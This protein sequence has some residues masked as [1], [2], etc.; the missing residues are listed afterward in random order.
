[1]NKKIYSVV[2]VTILLGLVLTAC[3]RPA[4]QAPAVTPTSG[5]AEIPF[6]IP[7]NPTVSKDMITK[8]TQTAL[9]PVA[10]AATPTAIVVVNTPAATQPPA[11]TTAPTKAPVVVPTATPGLPA[12]Y[13][14]QKGEFPYCIARRFNLDLAGFL[15]TNGLTINSR[16]AEGTDLKIPTGT[17][18]DAGKYGERSLKKHPDTYAVKTGD[19]IFSIACSYGDVDPNAIILANN[20]QS[21][22]TVTSGQSLQIP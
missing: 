21:P 7:S 2:L 22:F 14:I 13:T 4:S 15:S 6:P 11:P 9:T 1:M 3:A 10:A 16:I 17:T 12:T 20:L 18:W 5:T 8:G 19:T